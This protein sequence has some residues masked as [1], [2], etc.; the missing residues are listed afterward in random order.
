MRNYMNITRNW[1]QKEHSE[2]PHK[3][4]WTRRMPLQKEIKHL[5]HPKKE[6]KITKKIEIYN[7][8]GQ[9]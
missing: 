5:E 2:H 3:K 9:F 8:Y 1:K 6:E 4:G 7:H